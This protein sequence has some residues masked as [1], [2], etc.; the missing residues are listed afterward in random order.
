MFL[1]MATTLGALL[2][3]TLVAL[4]PATYIAVIFGLV[5]IY[6]AF[7]AVRSRRYEKPE[8]QSDLLASRLHMDGAYPGDISPVAYHVHAVPTGFSLMF[9]AGAISGLLGIGSGAVKVLA[10]DQAMRIPFKVSTTTTSEMGSPPRLK[11]VIRCSTPLSV[12]RKSLSSRLCTISPSAFR[13]VTGVLTK[14]LCSLM[15]F[16]GGPF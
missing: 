6:S 8:D 9:V 14:M 15:V 7:L 10:M 2:G 13:T 3:A 5:L 1:E 11:C 16:P 12:I 4:I